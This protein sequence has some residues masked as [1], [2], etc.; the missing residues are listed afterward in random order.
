M[1]LS[2]GTVQFGLDYGI[3]NQ[4]GKTTSKEVSTIL[5]FAEKNDV[6]VLDTAFAYGD[7]E[8]VLGRRDISGFKVITKMAAIQNKQID[9]SDIIQME[10]AFFDSLKSMGIESVYGLLIHS[11]SDLYKKNAEM[12]YDK[13]VE[14]KAR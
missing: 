9:S 1:K 11:S 5:T 2:L 10:K 4:L 6:T 8:K 12:I 14:L 7:S 13:L 3:T